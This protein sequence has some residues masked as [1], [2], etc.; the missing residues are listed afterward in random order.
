MELVMRAIFMHRSGLLAGA[1][2][3]M[4]STSLLGKSKPGESDHYAVDTL[5]AP[6]SVVLE[7][8]G[9]LPFGDRLLVCTRRG[10]IW[11]V[12]RPW[13]EAPE[14]ILSF[15]GLQ[16]PLGLL[17]GTGENAGWI[18]VSQRGEL[19][20]I[21]DDDGD[22]RFDRLET[23]NDDWELSGSYHEYTF[24][25]VRDARGDLWITLNRPFGPEPFGSKDWR[26]W[27]VRIDADN[28]AHFETA[29]LRSPCGLTASPDGEIFYTD[30]QGEWTPTN[31]LAVLQRGGFHGHPW[32]I[33][34]AKRPESNVSHPGGIPDR[35]PLPEFVDKVRSFTLPAVWFPYD[36]MGRSASGFA[37]DTTGGK[38]GPFEG[39]IFVGDQHHASVMRVD[40][41]KVDGLWQG[42][43][44]PF[45][46]G[47]QC[48][49]IRVAFAP[50][51]SLIVGQSNRGWASR[52]SKPYGVERL[53]FT[54]EAPF[55]IRS[56]KALAD[57]FRLEFTQPVDAATAID[58]SSYSMTRYTYRHHSD[59]GSPEILAEPCPIESVSV[60]PDGLSVELSVGN[61]R[62]LFVHELLA[63]GVRSAQGRPLLHPEAYYTLNRIPKGGE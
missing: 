48:G 27:A 7:A 45:R 8:G 20:R 42:A 38:F 47:L 32:G 30:N 6:E 60:A 24:G 17:E 29:G 51:G 46:E 26:G 25:P 23:V 15:E 28:Q 21:R 33:E 58:P 57:G 56:M 3:L 44:F 11:T 4:C 49:V 50:D 22:H 43:C 59:Y 18:Y 16:E 54:G 9:L 36:K 31:K 34:S 5:A 62:E 12:L 61:R 10:E 63:E 39:Q 52:G 55:E 53:R 1:L 35:T 40:L 37:W 2:A 13:S 41:E 19:S 14:F